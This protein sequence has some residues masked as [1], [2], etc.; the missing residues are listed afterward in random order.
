MITCNGDNASRLKYL[1]ILVLYYSEYPP[2]VAP[3]EQRLQATILI[4]H[5][6]KNTQTERSV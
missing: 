4:S 3:H 5:K 6:I 2:L 1:V